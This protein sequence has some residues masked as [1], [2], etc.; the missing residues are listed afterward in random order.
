MIRLGILLVIVL[1]SIASPVRSEPVA[2][3]SLFNAKTTVS[4]YTAALAF[5]APRNLEGASIPQLTIWGLHG[6]SALDPDLRADVVQGKLQL[7]F[8]TQTIFSID[9]PKFDDPAG[10]GQAAA[11]LTEA[12]WKV[13]RPL[14]RAGTQGIIEIFFRELFAH[15]DPYS[16]YVSPMEAAA[17]EAQ[18]W[19]RAG[20]GITVRRRGNSIVVEAVSPDSPGSDAGVRAGDWVLAVDGQRATGQPASLVSAW[21]A[22]PEGSPV[23]LSW[24]TDAKS[25]RAAELTRELVPPETVFPHFHKRSL[26][27]QVTGFNGNTEVRFAA[28]I[29]RAMASA[30]P[31]DGIVVDLRGNRGGL[32]AEAVGVA[33]ELLPE[34]IVATTDGR[35][36]AANRIWRSASGEL[37]KG[38]P[39]IV[40][41]DG[42]TASAAEVLAA[43]LA[44]RGRAVVVG[45]STT[46]KGLVQTFIALPD[47]GELFV[48]WSRVLAPRGWPLQG[49]GILP[50]VCTSLGQEE[51]D[52]QLSALAE[53]EQPMEAAL[54]RARSA[55]APV[56]AAELVEIRAACPAA[57]GE[58][59]DTD[60]AQ[61]LL[62]N[63]AAYAAALL[64]PIGAPVAAGP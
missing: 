34:G 30:R 8:G 27:L 11:L 57:V 51:L 50:Q 22:G 31:P 14:Q 35:D 4:V 48:T 45:S 29:Q 37:A 1:A 32:L 44:D 13:S 61:Y 47:G 18:R 62:R 20:I 60:A 63:P 16:R 26:L 21:L 58:A 39:I 42:N 5:I 53:G 19:G 41:V 15:L 6:L 46:G 3:I 43:A 36:P 33:D 56:P 40:L 17:D 24:R 25:I 38:I 49:L 9:A 64:P 54:A 55:R 7:A 52:R 59:G 10:W 23:R 28:D 2:N 12:G